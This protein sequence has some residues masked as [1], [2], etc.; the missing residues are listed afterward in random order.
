[1]DVEKA[2]EAYAMGK[3]AD[4]DAAV[5]EEHLLTCAECRAAVEQA[6]DYVRAIRAAAVEIRRG[7][8]PAR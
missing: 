5:F 6:D 3:I 8:Q 1:M 2:A 4:A 7:R